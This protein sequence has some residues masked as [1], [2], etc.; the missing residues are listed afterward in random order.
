MGHMDEEMVE[1]MLREKSHQ[2]CKHKNRPPT[3]IKN[4]NES[5]PE[6]EG[7][8]FVTHLLSPFI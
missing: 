4:N 6:L 5:L 8:H 1:K 3:I 7:D 2:D